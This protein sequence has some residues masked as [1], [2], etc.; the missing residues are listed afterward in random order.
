MS[1]FA[2]VAIV[3]DGI[4]SMTQAMGQERDVHVV[5]VYVFFGD[6]TY[7]DGIDLDAALFYRLL[8]G[9]AQLPTTSQPTVADLA[10]CTPNSP[11]RQRP[12]FPFTLQKR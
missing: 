6:Q 11:S 2:Q 3:T 10:N 9:S 7:H 8:R 12:S 4:S 5:P 1:E